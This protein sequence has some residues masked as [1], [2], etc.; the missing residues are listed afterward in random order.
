MYNGVSQ[1]GKV[2]VGT[3]RQ[4]TEL[5]DFLLPWQVSICPFPDQDK[6]VSTTA[7]SLMEFGSAGDVDWKMFLEGCFSIG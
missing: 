7:F 6:A 5:A 2:E 4:S 3:D 1:A